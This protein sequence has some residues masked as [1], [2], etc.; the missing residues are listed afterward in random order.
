MSYDFKR[1]F[2]SVFSNGVSTELVNTDLRP[3]TALLG[4]NFRPVRDPSGRT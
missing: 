1:S 3:L 2:S 4:L